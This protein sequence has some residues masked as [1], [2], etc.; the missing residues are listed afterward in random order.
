MPLVGCPRRGP[1]LSLACRHSRSLYRARAVAPKCEASSSPPLLTRRLSAG[2]LLLAVLPIPASSPQLP[3]ASASEA[4]AAEGES[5][6]SEGL[7]LER[8]TD[9][10]QGF[11]LLKPTSWPKVRTNLNLDDVSTA[12]QR[13]VAVGA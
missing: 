7:E 1:P 4:E 3:V 10:E 8:Y 13:N 12:W 11:T 9:Q 6:I 5:G 2:S